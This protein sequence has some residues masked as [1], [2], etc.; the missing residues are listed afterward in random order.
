MQVI[1]IDDSY[2]DNKVNTKLLKLARVS[3]QTSRHSPTHWR[4]I[5]WSVTGR[6]GQ[7]HVGCFSTF[8]C[9]E[10]MD[11]DGWTNSVVF[12]GDPIDVPHLHVECKH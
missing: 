5:T 8:K 2:I 4:L 11:L 9:R 7:H 3:R 6:R 1:L 10:S 12:R